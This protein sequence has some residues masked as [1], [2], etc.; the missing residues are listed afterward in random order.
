MVLCLGARTFNSIRRGLD[1]PEVKLA[2]SSLPTG[3]T[4][5]KNLGI[6]IYGVPHTGSWGTKNAGGIEKVHEI[7]EAL[8]AHFQR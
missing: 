1:Q 7:W 5:T 4:K 8:A 6:E 2:A 3:H